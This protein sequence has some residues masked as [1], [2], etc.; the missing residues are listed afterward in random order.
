MERCET[1]GRSFETREISCM[2]GNRDGRGIE[3][4]GCSVGYSLMPIGDAGQ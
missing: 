4:K 3:T 2:P 1:C